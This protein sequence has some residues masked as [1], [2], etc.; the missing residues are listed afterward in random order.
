MREFSKKD[1]RI[2]LYKQK[3]NLGAAL[4]IKFLLEKV[5]T[6]FFMIAASDDI[7]SLDWIEKAYEFA[8]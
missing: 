2:K 4:N 5:K 8:R 3:K 6:K 7:L 1:Q